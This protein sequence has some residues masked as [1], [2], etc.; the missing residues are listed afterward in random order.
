MSLKRINDNLL[1]YSVWIMTVIA[2]FIMAGALPF[3]GSDNEPNVIFT[4]PV[5]IG[6]NAVFVC[7][8]LTGISVF[9]LDYK[10]HPNPFFIITHLG[11]VL[12]LI[13][14]FICCVG[15]IKTGLVVPTDGKTPGQT[16]S[17][18]QSAGETPETPMAFWGCD[19]TCPT[20]R[21]D[22]FPVD[23]YQLYKKAQAIGEGAKAK[24]IMTAK[25]KDGFLD[26]GENGRVKE[27]ELKSDNGFQ[28]W[29][30]CHDLDEEHF[31]LL[32]KPPDKSY[33]CELAFKSPKSDGKVSTTQGRGDDDAILEDTIT[34]PVYVNHPGTYK[35]WRFY[36]KDYDHKRHQYVVL[37]IRRDPGRGWVIVGIWMIIIGVAGL[38]YLPS[39]KKRHAEKINEPFP[40][41]DEHGA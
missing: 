41:F 26:L 1:F 21:V 14:A 27:S 9:I 15:E 24:L 29:K 8:L 18:L 19:V 33:L 25:I 7:L 28:G 39:V 35:G 31:L 30:L 40:E 11:V 4:S 38:C 23:S 16:Q 10:K 5:F 37:T 13:G 20:F 32:N 3:I 22:Y 12:V 34:L 36:L 2:L 17:Q 6:L